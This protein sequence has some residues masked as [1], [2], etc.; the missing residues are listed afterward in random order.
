LLCLLDKVI[1][2]GW[3]EVGSF[4]IHIYLAKSP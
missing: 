3:M 2:I 1:D 4:A